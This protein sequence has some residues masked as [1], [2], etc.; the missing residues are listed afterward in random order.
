MARAIQDIFPAELLEHLLSLCDPLE[1]AAFAQTSRFFRSIIYATSDQHLWRSLYL[2]QDYLDDPRSCVSFLGKRRPAIDWKSELQ[3][4][5]R[6]KSVLDNPALCRPGEQ[7]TILRTLLDVSSYVPPSPHVFSD[8]LSLNL[9]W[10]AAVLRGGKFLHDDEWMPSAEGQQL[11]ARLHAQFGLTPEDTK[12]SR[13]V[14]SRAFVYDM[15]RYDWQNHFGPFLPDGSGRVNWV[16]VQAIHHVVSMHVVDVREEEDFIFTIFPMSM[17]FCQPI[18]PEGIDLDQEED[19]AGI[20]G[21]WTCAYCFC[22][23]RELLSASNFLILR[24]S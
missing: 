4:I 11:R 3:C 17:P 1:V 5:I 12:A 16:H 13:R 23:H 7:Y 19:W 10:V 14:D 6:A 22:D 15:R 8:Q 18:I 20:E 24:F 9:L 21:M 2:Q